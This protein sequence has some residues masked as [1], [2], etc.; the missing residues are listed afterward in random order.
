M[1]CDVWRMMYVCLCA[2]LMCY[3]HIKKI[4]LLVKQFQLQ[5]LQIRNGTRYILPSSSSVCVC[6]CMCV[7]VCVCV[8]CACVYVYVCVCVCVCMY[9]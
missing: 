7:C 8:M 2:A 6:V 3:A 1:M 5:V 9:V 4:N